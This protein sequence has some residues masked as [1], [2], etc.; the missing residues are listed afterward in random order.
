[1]PG[2]WNWSI[3][4]KVGVSHLKVLG[5]GRWEGLPYPECQGLWRFVSMGVQVNLGWPHQIWGG[6]TGSLWRD[7]GIS[8]GIYRAS[9]F[10]FLWIFHP[11]FRCEWNQS[12][13]LAVTYGI[14]KVQSQFQFI[15]GW[16][17]L[18]SKATASHCSA[19][20]TASYVP[21]EFA[22]WTSDPVNVPVVWGT[23]GG[24]AGFV[25]AAAGHTPMYRR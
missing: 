19:S 11:V 21:C 13:N 24:R 9:F 16:Q 3:C 23:K 8:Q 7:K 25:C 20:L 18:F 1:M 2:G 17:L 6:N 10:F 22:L 12:Y 5:L 14:E 15:T 4:W